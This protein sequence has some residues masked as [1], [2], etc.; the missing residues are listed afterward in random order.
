MA[1]R[2]IVEDI[3]DVVVVFPLH[4]NPEVRKLSYAYL[5]NQFNDGASS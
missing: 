4:M 1:V 5:E 3:E 2:D